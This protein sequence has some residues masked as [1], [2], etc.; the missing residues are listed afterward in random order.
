MRSSIVV[1][2]QVLL[3]GAGIAQSTCDKI[4]VGY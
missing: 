2:A 1:N 3:K 4:G